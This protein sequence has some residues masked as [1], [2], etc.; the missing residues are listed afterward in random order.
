MPSSETPVSLVRT[1]AQKQQ[2][3]RGK[4]IACDTWVHLEC[5]TKMG[6]HAQ[7]QMGKNMGM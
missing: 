3:E 6:K 2:L 4:G 5:G 1:A 7:G